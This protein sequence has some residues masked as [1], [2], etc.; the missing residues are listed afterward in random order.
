MRRLGAV[1]VCCV[2]LGY[3]SDAPAGP[4]LTARWIT[5]PAALFEALHGYL[6]R[7]GE[8]ML[9]K[10][11]AAGYALMARGYVDRLR[12]PNARW[13][14][15]YAE[16]QVGEVGL[17]VLTTPGVTNDQG[18]WWLSDFGG[19]PG[20]S[21][22]EARAAM[23]RTLHADGIRSYISQPK[24]DLW[25]YTLNHAR[26]G[27]AVAW[28]L[29][30]T[31]YKSVLWD[32]NLGSVVGPK[33]ELVNGQYPRLPSDATLD[34]SLSHGGQFLRELRARANA[35]HNDRELARISGVTH[36]LD[37]VPRGRISLP[38][39]ES[40]GLGVR[41]AG[42]ILGQRGWYR[43]VGQ[44]G[45]REGGLVEAFRGALRFAK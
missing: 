4:P 7:L 37:A 30:Y 3:A 28:G 34:A 41:S 23:N 21:M 27:G 36:E 15:I 42:E 13:I 45:L 8:Q 10:G 44:R 25:E 11:D 24:P 26:R 5:D 19:A 22:L 39:I 33:P 6:P 18:S 17:W 38:V 12:S 16:G 32:T 9:S 20:V 35:L 43:F 29:D 2:V 14:G 40:S 1:F 31:G